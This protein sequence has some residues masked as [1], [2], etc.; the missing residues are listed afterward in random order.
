[1]IRNSISRSLPA[2]FLILISALLVLYMMLQLKQKKKTL[3]GKT[4]GLLLYQICMLI[5]LKL[6]LY[7]F[8]FQLLKQ[9][10]ELYLIEEGQEIGIQ[11]NFL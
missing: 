5:G 11:F 3:V 7:I 10:M 2:F 9:Q 1:M 4:F 6:I 8:L